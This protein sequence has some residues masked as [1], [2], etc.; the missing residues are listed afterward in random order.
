MTL[1]DT[2]APTRSGSW[3]TVADIMVAG[4]YR[5]AAAGELDR[6]LG[7]LD[8]LKSSESHSAET[9]AELYGDTL[10]LPPTPMVSAGRRV[11]A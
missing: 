3:A 4:A 5:L 1:T 6:L 10:P 7:E 2:R 9:E 8:R 11:G